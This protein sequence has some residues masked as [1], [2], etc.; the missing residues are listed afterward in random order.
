MKPWDIFLNGKKLDTVYFVS[1][2]KMDEVRRS[3][4]QNDN[5]DP[6]IKVRPAHKQQP[7]KVETKHE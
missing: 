7:R 1:S 3:L 4:I 6:N 5:M 2:R